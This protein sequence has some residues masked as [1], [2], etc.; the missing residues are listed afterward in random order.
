VTWEPFEREA[1]RY[2]AW[3][4]TA[5]GARA[6]R[7]EKDLLDWLRKDFPESRTALDVGCGTG[8]FTS[9]LAQRGLRAVGLDR[10]PAMLAVLRRQLPACPALVADA[11][12]LP[13]R[14]RAVDLVVFVTTLEFLEDPRRALSEAARVA[15]RGLIVLALNRWSAG[16]LSRRF[17]PASRGALLPLARDLSPPELRRLMREAAGKRLLRLR[18]RTVLLPP[19]LSA[20][21]LRTPLG[22]IVGVAATLQSE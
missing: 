18:C 8:H 3:Y 12:H 19:P 7:A 2:E 4:E 14:D 6:S 15:R 17:G 1:E 22:D 21:P 10:A 5:R 11:H 20:G 16:A 9:W 13:L